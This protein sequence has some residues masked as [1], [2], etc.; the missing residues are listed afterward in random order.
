MEG[1]AIIYI[2]GAIVYFLYKAY[3]KGQ[4]EMKKADSKNQAKPQPQPGKSIQ[5][6]LDELKQQQTGQRTPT[7][8]A[9]KTIAKKAE[10]IA[11]PAA[12]I[13]KEKK[14]IAKKPV[15]VFIH[16]DVNSNFIEG[17]SS[18]YEYKEIYTDKIKHSNDF[19]II[20]EAKDETKP[21][22]IFNP[23]NI[24]EAFIG[25]LIFERKF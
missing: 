6:I 13:V 7:D 25:S 18:I 24:Q 2:V 16:E 11:K 12:P 17:Q 3:S 22:E 1:K 4:E 20:N 23:E 9:P 21:S 15:D 14:E 8:P 19:E 10:Q 5:E